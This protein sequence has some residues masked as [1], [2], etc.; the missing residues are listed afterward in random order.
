MAWEL[1]GWF[2][3]QAQNLLDMGICKEKNLQ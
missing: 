1:Q 3:R 2:G